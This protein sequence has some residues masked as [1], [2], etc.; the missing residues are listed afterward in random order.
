MRDLPSQCDGP[1]VIPRLG[2]RYRSRI[3]RLRGLTGPLLT[4]LLTKE[5]LADLSVLH[6]G[7]PAGLPP[8]VEVLFVRDVIV[9]RVVHAPDGRRRSSLDD[10]A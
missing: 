3:D 5:E 9:R 6:C 7:Y 8:D 10:K 4:C 1:R 2:T